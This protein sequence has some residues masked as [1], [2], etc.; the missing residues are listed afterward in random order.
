MKPVL[1]FESIAQIVLQRPQEHAATSILLDLCC[2]M[3]AVA[4][5]F[6]HA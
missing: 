2:M 6:C 4:Y 1:L 3:E 5:T